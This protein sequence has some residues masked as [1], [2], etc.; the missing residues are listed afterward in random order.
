MREFYL[1]TVIAFMDAF[2][3]WSK[4]CPWCKLLECALVNLHITGW[5]PF[6]SYLIWYHCENLVTNLSTWYIISSMQGRSAGWGWSIQVTKWWN[7]SGYGCLGPAGHL[8]CAFIIANC[9]LPPASPSAYSKGDTP[10]LQ[11]MKIN[12]LTR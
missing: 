4:W 12:Y 7:S 1:G 9:R 8:I 10:Y 5:T 2:H 6:P 11:Q 3:S